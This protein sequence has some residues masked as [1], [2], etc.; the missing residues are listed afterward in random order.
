M[1]KPIIIK[2]ISLNLLMKVVV[3]PLDTNLIQGGSPEWDFYELLQ[4]YL[5]LQRLD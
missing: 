2:S 5:N 4:M 1:S 3:N